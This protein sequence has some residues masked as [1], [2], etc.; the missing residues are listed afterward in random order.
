MPTNL[1]A[2]LEAEKIILGNCLLTDSALPLGDLPETVFHSG[3]N[4]MIARSIRA[5]AEKKIPVTILE[6]VRDLEANKSTVPASY[7]SELIDGISTNGTVEYYRK[8]LHELAE[9]REILQAGENIGAAIEHGESTEEIIE[10]A[11][12]IVERA[13]IPKEVKTAAQGK[14]PT[15]PESA[16]HPLAL[17]YRDLMAPTTNAPD[18][19]HLACFLTVFGATLHR[20]VYTVISERLYP[21]M[22]TVLVGD[23]GDSRK[24]SSMKKAFRFFKG[25]ST[26]MEIIRG[27]DSAESFKKDVARFQGRDI[28]EEKRSPVIV[29]ISELRSLI[30]KANKT[31]AENII[32]TL[33][34]AYDGEP[35]EGR[36]ASS[37]SSSP[38]PYISF[39]MGSSKP[40]IQCF[41]RSDLEGGAGSR[42]AFIFGWPKKRIA[43]PPPPDEEMYK[44]LVGE[45]R[46]VINYWRNTGPRELCLTPAAHK[47]WESF[48]EDELPKWEPEDEFLRSLSRRYDQYALKTAMDYAALDMSPEVTPNHLTCGIMYVQFILHTLRYVFDDYNVPRWVQEE[49]R[50]VETVKDA[51]PRGIRRRE[52][53]R[54]FSALG[55]ETFNRHMKALISSEGPLTEHSIGKKVWLSFTE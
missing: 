38:E 54:K 26:D 44:S 1:P 28:P 19:F 29:Q 47:M 49:R 25:A 11:R 37:T 31:G 41:K 5:L 15:L 7:V 23:P 53:Q 32:P 20:S 33:C 39:Q 10:R 4:R 30:A 8:R 43:Y 45:L 18:S 52:L 22:F 50:L 13:T 21:N 42:I 36:A 17:R 40:Y 3:Q 2:D 27:V 16:W 35:L 46:E 34:D 51:M 48:Y 14:Y 24:T 6:V 12:T 9:Q 55:A